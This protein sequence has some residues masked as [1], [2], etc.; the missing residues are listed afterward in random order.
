MPEQEKSPDPPSRGGPAEELIG[1]RRWALFLLAPLL[2][3]GPSLLPG[4]RFLPQLPVQY[5]PLSAENPAAEE[6]ASI[7]R[8]YATSDRIL[9]FLTD[10]LE[11]RRQ[12]KSGVL[13][14]WDSKVGMGMPLFGGSLVS[15]TYPPNGFAVLLEPDLA[16]GWLALLCL[17]IGGTGVWAFFRC[18]GLSPGAAAVGV[19]AFQTAGWAL[20]NL[21]FPM[22][23]DAAVW[24][25]WCLWA[26]EALG[27]RKRGAGFWLF[28]FVACSFLA[29]FVP[30]AIFC[31]V[32]ILVFGLWRFTI[33]RRAQPVQVIP[34]T[35]LLSIGGFVALG[36][37]ASSVQLLPSKEAS[38]QSIRVEKSAEVLAS[39]SLP[40]GAA[41]SLFVPDLFGSPEAYT[42]PPHPTSVWLSRAEESAQLLTLQSPEWNAFAGASVL[43]LALVALFATPR[44][45]LFPFAALIAAWGFAQGWPVMRFFYYLPGFD[46][47]SP[48]RALAVQWF[49]WPWLAALG[50]QAIIDRRPRAITTL[51]VFAFIL[52]ASAFL[53]WTGFDPASWA[54]ALVDSASLRFGLPREDVLQILSEPAR[55]EAGRAL[56][57]S[58]VRVMGAGTALFA[59]GL[60]ALL[61]GRSPASFGDGPPAWKLT[62]ALVI[63]LALFLVTQTTT[64]P[65]RVLLPLAL[66]VGTF[67]IAGRSRNAIA[68]A[69]WLPFVLVVG[70]EGLSGSAAHIQPRR[71]LGDVFPSS[72][73]IDAVVSAA[74]DGRVMRL[75]QSGGIVDVEAL[76]RPNLLEAYGVNDLTPYTVFTPRTLVELGTTL[77]PNAAYRSGISSFSDVEM[78][79]HPIMDLLRVTAVLSTTMLDHPRL[80]SAYE[81][82]RFFVYRRTGVPPAVHVVREAVVAE[83][84]EAALAL[85]KS[86]EFD[87]MHKVVLAPGQSTGDELDTARGSPEKLKVQRVTPSRL[88]VE[89]ESTG[90]GWLVFHEQFYPGW[91]ATLDGE[92]VEILRVN[93]AQ[94]AIRV[95]AGEHI[96]R[97]KYKPWSL[98]FGVLASLLA[99]A[100]AWWLAFRRVNR[101]GLA[102][103]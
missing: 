47:G 95:P 11:I 45:A 103:S 84:D 36:I 56:S 19:V 35:A 48:V 96:V 72:S 30:I 25:P 90:G 10:Q 87:P 15:P 97:T 3:I 7:G 37:L 98:R 27:Q 78:V 73:A 34:K 86:S 53:F 31:A 61:L 57:D 67:L 99:T 49:L 13:P 6:A 92:D 12:I 93:H 29:G 82:P 74:G 22:K 64:N 100:C 24:L 14:T 76:A 89:I 21:Q 42:A 4:Y 83:S 32:V 23:V 51:L 88:D 71:L 101:A 70:L 62:F 69:G 39:E 17:I 59:A 75:N 85:L 33:E 16:A 52:C 77:D 9:P 58:S 5:A 66:G 46:L 2:L 50:T 1:W 80:E 79:S 65:D 91:K 44:R 60:C 102:S 63:V 28:L 40:L 55:L 8:S 26:V 54:T 38:E 68:M 20:A 81:S 18:R 43:V 94:R 41:A